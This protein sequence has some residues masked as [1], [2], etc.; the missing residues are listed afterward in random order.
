MSRAVRPRSSR[1]GFS[2][3]RS[4]L[5]TRPLSRSISI[6][7]CASRKVAPPGTVVPT[8]GAIVGSRKST[9]RLTCSMAPACGAFQEG[10]KR[11]RDTA[12]VDGAH[13]VHF[14]L[15]FGQRPP[16]HRVDAA[17]ADHADVSGPQRYG[18]P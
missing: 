16:F 15:A 12:L 11:R 3:T 8:P 9:S 5:R 6:A 10:R 18:R 2:S 7:R 1:K 4:R 13:V 14:D 17:E